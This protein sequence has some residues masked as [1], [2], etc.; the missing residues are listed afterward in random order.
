MTAHLLNDITQR[1]LVSQV[2]NIEQLTQKLETPQVVYCGFDP[3]AGSLHIGHLVPL[4]MLKRFMDAGHQGVALIGGATGLIGDPS[5]KATERSLNTKQT[6]SQWVD[7]LANQ[8]ESVLGPHLNQPLQ[9]K[10][11]AD[12]FS[13]I[14]VLDFFR[15]VGKHF[16]INTM[17]NRES[18]KQRL[19]RPDQGLSFTEFSYSLLQSYDFAKLN[20]ELNCT[21]QIGGNDQWGNIV[22]GID[23]TRRLNQQTVFG[24]TLPLITKS[25]GTK[26]GKTEGGAI[27]LNP[28]K[29]SPYRFYQFWLNCEDADVYNFLRFYTF[30]SVKEIEAIEANDKISGQKPQAQRILAEQLTRFVHAEEGLASAQRLTELLFNGQVQTLTLA[31]LEQLE[32]DG[33]T[34]NTISD[35]QISI[36]ELLV[37]SKLA[38]SKRQARELI[39]A[40]AI[41]INSMVVTDEHAQL[42]ISLFERFWIMQRGKKQFRLIKLV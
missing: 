32:Q 10:N 38:S 42:D 20:S 24:L 11:N 30:L 7:A 23:L 37:K 2:S 21:L 9:I 18:V 26:F 40:N 14:D 4:I 1:G 33:L 16:S 19:Q 22:S 39:T 35:M 12:W 41:K 25:D 5:F 28:K 15:D 36:A 6:V 29:T 31:E 27:W 3:T 34:V 17:I 13:S 8:V